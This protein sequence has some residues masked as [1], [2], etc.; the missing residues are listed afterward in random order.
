[1]T[2]SI[3]AAGMHAAKRRRATEDM[4]VVERGFLFL[5]AVS[6]LILTASVIALALT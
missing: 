4:D 2:T 5:V 6:F 3:S 1:M